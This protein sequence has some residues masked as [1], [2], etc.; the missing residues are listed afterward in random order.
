MKY[1]IKPTPNENVFGLIYYILQLL[2]LPSMILVGNML[3]ANPLP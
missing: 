3:L 2:I 1:F